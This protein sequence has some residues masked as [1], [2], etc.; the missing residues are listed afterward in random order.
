[1]DLA[2]AG[3]FNMDQIDSTAALRDHFG[4]VSPLAQRKVLPRLDQHC[5]EFIKLSPF[6]VLASADDAGGVDASPRGDAPGFVA[7]LD[8]TTLLLPDRPGNN[9]VDSYSNIVANPGV[10]L[11]FFVPGVD[12]TLRVNGTA[13]IISDADL[14]DG[15]SVNGKPPKAG[16]MI[17]VQEAFFHCGKALKRSHLWDPNRQIERANFPSLGRIIADQTGQCSADEADAL[18]ENAYRVKLY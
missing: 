10:G 6:L 7:I 2:D 8:D 3:T 15:L 9:R 12:E 1:L 11:L 17:T 4:A 16:L 18:I 13:V 5:R 14:L